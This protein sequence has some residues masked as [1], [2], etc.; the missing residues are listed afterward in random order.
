MKMNKANDHL[1]DV[2]KIVWQNLIPFIVKILNKLGLEG[3]YIN[4]IIAICKEIHNAYH[5]QL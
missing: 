5:A 1:I 3:N 4:I 2:K